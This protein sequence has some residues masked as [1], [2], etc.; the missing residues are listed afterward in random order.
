MNEDILLNGEK[1]TLTNC[2][3]SLWHKFHMNYEADPMMNATPY[4][5][6]FDCVEKEYYAKSNDSTRKYFIIIHNGE[7]IG[8]IYLKHMDMV[9]KSTEF[10]I[11]LINDSVKGY[12]FGTEAIYLL[13]EY[14]FNILGF[15]CILADS[16]LRNTR[17]QHVLEKVGFIYTH[18]D[19]VFKYYKLESKFIYSR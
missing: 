6:D 5:Y 14:T 11:A 12:G 8:T 16:V 10:G 17:S 3:K 13:I 7:A 4:T 15:E 9:K 18:E 19:S 2:T 1:I